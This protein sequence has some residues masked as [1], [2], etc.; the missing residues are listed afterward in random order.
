MDPPNVTCSNITTRPFAPNSFLGLE[1]GIEFTNVDENV[2]PSG[3]SYNV[4]KGFIVGD[5]FPPGHTPVTLFVKDICQNEATCLFYVENTLTE[6]PVNCPDLNINVSTD[7]DQATYTFNLDFGADNVTKSVDSYRYHGD[8]VSV[9]LTLGGSPLG[10]SVSIGTHEVIALIYDD[11]L[12]KTCTGTS[13]VKD[14]YPPIVSCLNVTLPPESPNTFSGLTNGTTYNYTDASTDPNGVTYNVTLEVDLFPPGYTP[15][16][17]FAVDAFN[18]SESCLFYVQNT[19]TELPVNC[20]DLNRNVST[21]VDQ[22]TYTFNLDFGADNV[23]KSVDSYRYHGDGVS[24]N[25]TLGGSPLGSSVSIGTH[26]VIALIYDDVLNKTC[27]GTSVVKDTYPPIVSCLN[28]TL[29][30]ESPNTF[31]G[32]TNGTT[33]N[34]TDASTDPNGVTYNVTLEVDLFPPGY[35]PVTMFA[36]DAF[37]NSESCLFYV[38][39]TL[40][41]LPVNCPDLNRNVSTDV[42]QATYTFNLDFGADNVTKS[43]D[44]YRYH[45]DGVSVNLTLGGSPLGSSVS[46]G[47]H[48]V[49][50]LI[51]DDVLNKTCTGTSVVKDTYPPIVSCLNVTLP[52]E[53]PNTFSGLTNGTTYNYTDASTDPNGV[54]YNV[55]LE[56]DLFP[57]GYTPV[58]MFAVDAFNN[59]ES[60]LFYVQ[61]TLT[62]LPVNC[63]DLNRNV[64]TDVDQATYTFNLDF[65]ADNVT[66]SVDSYRYHGDGVSVNLTLGGSPL[67]SSVSIGTHEVIALIY[68]DVL[69]KTCTGTSVVKDTYPPIVS[70]LNVTLPP[71]SPNTFSGLTN[72]TTY[73]YTDASTDPN[74][75]T[76]NVTLEVDLFPPGYTPVTMFA[77]DAFNNSESC[78]FYVQNTLTELPVNCPDLNRNVSTDVDQATYTFN[79]DFGA[80]NVTK[81][82]DSYRYHGDGVSVNLT[83]GGSPL[84]SSVSIGTHEVIALIY[85]DVL[86]KTCTGTSVVKDTYPPIV[87][88]LNVTL[89]PESPNTFSGLTNGTTYNYTDASTDPNGVTYNVTLE[90][91]LFPPGYT[92]VTMFAVD[93]F[94]NSESCLFYVQNTLTEL[95]VNCPDLNRNVSTDVD[96]ATYTFNLDFGADNVTKSVDSYR[97]HGDGVS[98]NLTLGGSPLGSSVSIGTHEVIALI[99][100]DVLNKTCTGTSVVKDTYPPIVSCLN[101]TLPP[102]S[103]NTFSGL[104]NGTTYN[105]TDASTDPNGVTYNVTL[106]VDLFPPGYTPVTMFAVDAFNNSE[107]CLFYV[108]NTLTELP[109]NCPDLNRNVSTDVDQATYTFNLDFGADNVTKSVDSYRYHGDGVS[110]NLTLGGSPLG[111]SVSIGTHE[112]VALIYDDVLNKTCTGTYNIQDV[113]SPFITCSNIT[114]PFGNVVHNYDATVLDNVDELP[115]LRVDFAPKQPG[116][117]L[118]PGVNEISAT[119]TDSAGNINSTIF[120]IDIQ[121]TELPVNCPD[122]NRTIST[123][124]DQATYTFTPDFETDHVT[125]ST[126]NYRYYGGGVSVNLTL[127]G[128]PVWSDVSIGTH[129]IVALI[130]DDELNKTCTGTYNIQGFVP[131][132]RSLLE[133]VTVDCHHLLLIGDFNIQVDNAENKDAKVFS[134]VLYSVGLAQHVTAPTHQTGHTLDLVI[135]RKD[136]HPLLDTSCITGLPS[137]HN[138]IV[139]TLN[140]TRPPSTKKLIKCRKLKDIDVEHLI[141]DVR[142]SLSDLP[143]VTCPSDLAEQYNH[144]M[145]DLL[146]N[147]APEKTVLISVR[148]NAPWYNED[149]REAKREKRRAERHLTRNENSINREIY[150]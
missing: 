65:G 41:E 27:T 129:E 61:N 99:Y 17:M 116:Q 76:Y 31:S 22:A 87:S 118:D 10:S 130:Y 28:V 33:Y 143:G 104:T 43:V 136:K 7:V 80:D 137:D 69:N 6:L 73:N 15:V 94:N 30:P 102:E 112:V 120:Y 149:V 50:A 46:I 124:P 113:E 83:L 144:V 115:S 54:T 32:L 58:T 127:G 60:C 82:V 45:G 25:L 39:N 1:A 135:T 88:C 37:N 12:N 74:G 107:S 11:V 121:I 89:P 139:C 49:I 142:S 35:T 77:V 13:V 36:V 114:V 2:D 91:D 134:D 70:C 133:S 52:P 29:P 122:L 21:D 119:V 85:D 18:N 84:G 42:D 55:T 19:L 93:A 110:V 150:R 126:P 66:K 128:S 123:D 9:N 44:S 147:H 68:D 47:T 16:T 53:S 100:D 59:S 48:E 125:K 98:V 132:F 62:E 5:L 4:T 101:V 138:A 109:V 111:S 81:S 63:P 140:F 103:P 23:T 131:D 105:Y 148:P 34:Y 20:P 95:P 67:G 56:V 86:N 97:Y 96:Q 38:Q 79:L 51:Y 8:G 90:V 26:E 146:D 71:E 117:R 75:V 145:E 57:P 106:E 141:A 24:V 108:Q 40:T 64:S 78:L 14:T 3:A 92:P 72:G